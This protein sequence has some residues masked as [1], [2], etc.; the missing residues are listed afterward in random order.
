[1]AR[2]KAYDYNQLVMV[3]VSL[4]KQLSPTS[5]EF[6]IHKLIEERIDTSIFDE[7]YRNDETGCCAYD[8][9]I[10]LKIILFAY[11]RGILHSRRMERACREN[12]IFMALACGQQPDHSTLAAFVSSMGSERIVDLFS[13]I[14]LVCDEEGLL[15]G[16]HFSLDGL[17]L[18][19]NASKEWS[20][21]HAD[22]RKKKEKL[23]QKV[24]AA[25]KEQQKEDIG[26]EDRDKQREEKRIKRLTRNAERIGKFLEENKER[27]GC[28]GKEKQSNVT[29]NESSKMM[30][31]H[32]VIQG[33]NANALVD[34]KHQV[35]MHAEAFS[36]GEDAS[37]MGPMLEGAK[38]ILEKAGHGSSALKGKIISADTGFFSE[39]NIT[40]CN[41][42]E[43]DAYI[44]DRGFRNR[45]PR[46]ADAKR[47]RRSV[48]KHKKRYKSK[49]R[50]FGPDD[51]KV[52]DKTGRL[53]C[54][55]GANLFCSGKDV[56][57][58]D[59]YRG[60]KYKAPK[61]ACRN[62]ELRS[63]CLR[64]PKSQ[65]RQ[66]FYSH[67][68]PTGGWA[69]EMKAKIDTIEGRKMYGKR[70]KI[71]EPVFGNIRSQKDLDSFT[72]RG[73]SKI[74]IQ[75]RLYCLVHNIE[76]ILHFGKNW[77]KAA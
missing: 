15:G 61:T 24:Q 5:L 22:L 67:T 52:D 1:M 77:T 36:E 28:R 14:L 45:D 20:G 9:K 16:T 32:G 34:E 56:Q 37:N 21:T 17:K 8:P 57:T 59:G 54:P 76:K 38:K 64:S 72:L 26:G 27:K 58:S 43:V 33:Y 73:R 31:S 47:H 2:Y 29:D 60:I 7:K 68:K 46:F 48:D 13:Q 18:P 11:S 42:E 69:N 4:D 3:P 12:I 40:A 49:R 66:V 30:S 62:C 75:W 10:L 65:Q 55:A 53:K 39:K 74:N 71:V 23:E 50:W 63:K 41:A 44:P 51:F 25:I 35:V 6:A 70:L 19:S